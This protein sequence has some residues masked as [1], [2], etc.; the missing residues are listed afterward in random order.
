MLARYSHLESVR[1]MLPG[2]KVGYLSPTSPEA[3]GRHSPRPLG[4][5]DEANRA[6]MRERFLNSEYIN[7]FS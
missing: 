2:E 1:R 4:L 7:S 6:F 5:V 3:E